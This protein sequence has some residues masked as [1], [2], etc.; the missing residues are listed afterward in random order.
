MVAPLN[1]DPILSTTIYIPQANITIKRTRTFKHRFHICNT[2]D[3]PVTESF[4][5]IDC[6]NKMYIAYWQFC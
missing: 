4:I 2:A 5:E 3:I 6:F 1:I